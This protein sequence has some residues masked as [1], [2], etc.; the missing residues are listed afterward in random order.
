[1]PHTIRPTTKACGRVFLGG[2]S[3]VRRPALSRSR[4]PDVRPPIYE[5]RPPRRFDADCAR[6]CV[7][8]NWYLAHRG[9]RRTIAAHTRQIV[10]S[11]VLLHSDQGGSWSRRSSISFHSASAASLAPAVRYFRLVVRPPALHTHTSIPARRRPNRTVTGYG[12]DRRARARHRRRRRRRKNSIS[13]RRSLTR[14]QRNRLGQQGAQ[15]IADR[16]QSPWRR[17]IYGI[18]QSR[19]QPR[20][21]I[22]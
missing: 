5:S 6:L 3:A 14:Q 13:V 11:A 19:S 4:R 15:M 8:I 7:V 1:M 10:F 20:S 2:R 12:H 18:I 17:T 21:V 16:R 22:S 9:S